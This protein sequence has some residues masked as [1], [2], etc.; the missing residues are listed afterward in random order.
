MHS[1]IKGPRRRVGHRVD[2]PD[3]LLDAAVPC[4]FHA[5]GRIGVCAMAVCWNAIHSCGGGE[6]SVRGFGIAKRI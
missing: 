2:L 1:C 6:G 4:R 5:I 3:D